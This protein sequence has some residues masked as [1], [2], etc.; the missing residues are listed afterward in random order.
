M[1]DL[2][3]IIIPIYNSYKYIERCIKSV[4]C[5][6]YNNLEILC[7]NDG[8]TD[9]SLSVLKKLKDKRI[10]IINKEN[11]GVSDTR[12]YGINHAKGKFIMF[13]DSDDWIEENY[14]ELMYNKIKDNNA[15]IVVS[16]YKKIKGK[17][18]EKKSIYND[19]KRRYREDIT[20]P[21]A[22][23]DYLMTVEFNPCWK[24]LISLDLI[25][26]NQ[27]FFNTSLNY[28]EDMLFSFECYMKSKKTI[29]SINYGYNY[30]INSESVMR[31]FDI[32][33]ITKYINDNRNVSDIIIEK[34]CLE[35]N[36]INYLCYKTLKT[37]NNILV[38]FLKN[39]HSY[40]DFK[41]FAC[42]ERKTYNWYFKNISLLREYGVKDNISITLLKYNFI[43]LYYLIKIN[44][45]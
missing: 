5:Q 33:K 27:I 36:Q 20:Y 9:E 45:R 11:T 17:K 14:V 19:Y 31:D 35:K 22:I 2:I 18:I 39:N 38:K 34:Y 13:V 8:S 32:C 23:K 44:N 28:N 3:S 10:I 26:N 6:T 40:K 12:N 7:I 43:F 41:N 15:E 4:C 42:K 24:Q 29:Y 21:Y 1:N 30:Y 25:R 16:G 37:Y